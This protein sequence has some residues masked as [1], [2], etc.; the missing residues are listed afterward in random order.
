MINSA[1]PLETKGKLDASST[2]VGGSTYVKN[3][4]G[5]TKSRELSVLNPNPEIIRGVNVETGALANMDNSVIQNMIQNLRSNS[6]SIICSFL[7]CVLRTPE[8]FDCSRLTAMKCSRSVNPFA[9]IG[10]GG[11]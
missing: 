9:R 11:R 8:L 1:V 2:V 6:N 5:T 7:K 10:S 3:P 4:T